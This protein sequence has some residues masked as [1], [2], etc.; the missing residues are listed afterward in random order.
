MGF[1]KRTYR[2][3]QLDMGDTDNRTAGDR[4]G[5]L[6]FGIRQTMPWADGLLMFA[7]TIA[8]A[9][10]IFRFGFEVSK[11]VFTQFKPMFGDFVS[12]WTS[13]YLVLKG[14]AAQAYDYAVLNE[15]QLQMYG[16]GG[17]P[18]M[19]PP[20]WLLVISPAALLSYN[21]S[22]FVYEGLQ[23]LLL[24]IACR[25]LVRGRAPLWILIAFPAVIFG[26]MHGQNTALNTALLAGAIA[27][28]DRNRPV[29]AGILIGLL[30]YKP[31]LGILIPIALLAG[32]EYRVFAAAA[33]TT[34][35]F[36]A[37]SWLVLGTEVWLAFFDTIGFAREWLM[38]GQVPPNKYASILGWLRQFG[39][40]N[41]AGTI[42][43]AGGVILA[44]GAVIWAW[45]SH[46]PLTVKAGLLVTATCLST[47]Y[48]LDY[49][50]GVLV[51]PAL[52]L[53]CEGNR[54]GFLRYEKLALSAAV[55]GLLVSSGWGVSMTY[56][57]IGVPAVLLFGVFAHRAYVMSIQT[58]EREFY[59]SG[60]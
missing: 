55:L 37:V 36:A 43:Q 17:L 24:V 7:F 46:L 26:I 4:P 30:S 10:V 27:A 31:Q 19:Y 52:L 35:A 47:P 33:V 50:L 32:R 18:F 48:L 2:L 28:M 25:F 1:L 16:Q 13:S 42:V 49:D 9:V 6:Q 40:S 56:T 44:V 29:L 22:A 23:A 8:A 38:S 5:A 45:R 3:D 34:L 41:A 60:I 14:Q 12:F 51:I 15:I 59:P 54:S 39:V 58:A 21:P 20:T 57:A 53:I 11:P